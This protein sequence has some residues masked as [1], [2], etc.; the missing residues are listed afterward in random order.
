MGARIRQQ[1]LAPLRPHFRPMAFK[2]AHSFQNR[3]LDVFQIRLA[4][5]QSLLLAIRSRLPPPVT[6]HVLHCVVNEKKLLLYTDSAA[7]ASQ[8]RFLKEEILQSARDAHGGTIDKLQIRILADQISEH[9]QP[10][11]KASLPSSEKIAMLS[12]QAKTMGDS[13]LRQ[14]LQRLSATL[15]KLAD[16]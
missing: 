13:Q 11:R 8:L 15:A 4:K 2:L 1:K 9:P 5:Q 14:A 3:A 6:D 7:W 12:D 16:E 10:R